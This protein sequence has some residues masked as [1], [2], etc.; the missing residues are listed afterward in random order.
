M[1]KRGCIVLLHANG[2]EPVGIERFYTLIEKE[3]QNIERKQWLLYTLQK[4]IE[5]EILDTA[6]QLKKLSPN[7]KK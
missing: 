1:P 2:N 4:S 6:A 3:K 7:K 5:E